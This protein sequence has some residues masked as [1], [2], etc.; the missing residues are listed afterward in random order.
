MSSPHRQQHQPRRTEGR[1]FLVAGS[2]GSG[3]TS[4]TVQQVAGAHRLLVWD[5]AGEWGLKLRLHPVRSL[6]ELHRCI[7]ADIHKPGATRIA[8][9]GSVTRL[10]FETFCRLAWV[11]LRTAPDSVLV[12]EELADVTSPGKAPAAWGEI[13]RKHRHTRGHVY[14]LT[15]RPAESD[16]TI[17]GNASVIHAGRMNMATDRDYIA[18]VLDVPLVQVTALGD[19]DYIERNMRTRVLTRGRVTFKR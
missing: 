9:L 18:K 13:V 15:Q 5:S 6:D 2:A 16:K 4:W 14:A 12:V 19:L 7:A 1:S 17:V 3:K 11:W 10:H 8:Y